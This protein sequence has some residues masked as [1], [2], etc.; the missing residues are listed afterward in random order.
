M[1]PL[2]LVAG[3]FVAETGGAL[4]IGA[5]TTREMSMPLVA[6]VEG[7]LLHLT[8]GERVRVDGT[9]GTVQRLDT[10]LLGPKSLRRRVD[11]RAEDT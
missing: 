7:A 4:T 8:D 9:T 6:S 3:G 5:E 10:P 11:A 2:C 1:S